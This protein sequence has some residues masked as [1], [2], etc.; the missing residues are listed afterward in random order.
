MLARVFSA[1]VN[2][3]EAFP[4]EVEFN[5]GWGDTTVVTIMSISLFGS[6]LSS[7]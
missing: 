1:G 5:S 4:V 3:I 2:G 7:R 6:S